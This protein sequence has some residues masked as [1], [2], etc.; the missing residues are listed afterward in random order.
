M[1][2]E[3]D[4]LLSNKNNSNN[5]YRNNNNNNNNSNTRVPPRQDENYDN[6]NIKILLV[7][8]EPDIIFWAKKVL[9]FL[10]YT[11]RWMV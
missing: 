9:G 3:E 1:L 2:V 4:S 11:I 6:K 8:D 7:D 5:Y 10:I